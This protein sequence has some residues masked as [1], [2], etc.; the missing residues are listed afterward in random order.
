MIQPE[1]LRYITKEYIKEKFPSF[2]SIVE[3]GSH[4]G[5]D[6][7]EL[8]KTWPDAHIY[9]FEPVPE[10]F[11]QLC[12]NT[13]NISCIHCY[14]Y[15]FGATTGEALFYLSSKEC[16][17]IS[18]LLEPHAFISKKG[19]VSFTPVT[20]QTVTLDHWAQINKVPSVDFLWLDLQG[21]ELACL[22][23]SPTILETV[24]A[25]HME[26]S[27]TERYKNN[28]LYPEIKQWLAQQNFIIVAEALYRENWGNILCMRKEFI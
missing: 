5:R 1:Q 9:A 12:E 3:A 2:K 7:L 19:P 10:L 23:T 21:F 20:V 8:H 11:E 16:T 24:K 28:P 4:K 26:V 22:N 18:S 6:T 13:K 25:I 17:A 15:A 14:R 27:L